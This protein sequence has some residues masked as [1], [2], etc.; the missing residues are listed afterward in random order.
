MQS[1]V[2]HHSVVD[3]RRQVLCRLYLLGK[4]YALRIARAQH[5]A[6]G[7]VAGGQQP[8]LEQCCVVTWVSSW[9]HRLQTSART[10][11]VLRVQLTAPRNAVLYILCP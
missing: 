3:E 8:C 1:R 7:G 6:Y 4:M 9:L 2:E 5:L 10:N 11:T